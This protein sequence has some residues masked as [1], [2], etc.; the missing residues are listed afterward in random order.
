MYNLDEEAH[1]I[2]MENAYLI[3]SGRMRITE[4]LDKDPEKLLLAFNPYKI[5]KKRIK[6]TIEALIQHYTEREEYEKCAEL[7]K[8]KK[9][10]L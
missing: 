5:T 9:R 6:T 8:I 1:E 10:I 4:M 7:V 2:A 3:I